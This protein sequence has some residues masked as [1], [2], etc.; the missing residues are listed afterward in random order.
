MPGTRIELVR[1][2][3]HRILS[4]MDSVSLGCDGSCQGTLERWWDKA[5]ACIVGLVDGALLRRHLIY[6]ASAVL[7]PFTNERGSDAQ[8]GS[9]SDARAA[10]C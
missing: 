4:L 2:Y 1:G 9:S 10:T 5:L 7:P 6:S 3:P 8:G